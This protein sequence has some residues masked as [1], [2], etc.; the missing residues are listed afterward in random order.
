MRNLFF[1][2]FGG[3]LDRRSSYAAVSGKKDRLTIACWHRPL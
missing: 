1:I 2:L 3:V